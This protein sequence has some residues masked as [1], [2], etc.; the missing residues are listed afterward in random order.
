MVKNMSL[1]LNR[2]FSLGSEA[3]DLVVAGIVAAFGLA[4]ANLVGVIIDPLSYYGGIIIGAV[5]GLIVHEYGHRTAGLRVG[6]VS[7]FVLYPL[8]L[9]IT[10][11][12]GILRSFGFWFTLIMPG[13]VATSCG[14]EI[15]G[16]HIAYISYWGP[17]TNIVLSLIARVL[18]FFT[19]FRCCY[20]FLY[21]FAEM[22]A[23]L[24]L[25][26]LL[27]FYPLDGAKILRYSPAMWIVLI[28]IA[29]VLLYAA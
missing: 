14:Y 11:I 9:V 8:G 29:G 24:A 25:F 6:C 2:Y 21:G 13:F 10:L 28:V 1:G 17:L 27:P 18:L 23:W 3:V 7:R 26:N 19:M 12:F 16:R 15:S 20:S 5:V 22:N 4:G